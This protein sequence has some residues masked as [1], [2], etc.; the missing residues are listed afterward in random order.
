MDISCR[1]A[2]FL[3]ILLVA[4]QRSEDGSNVK[5]AIH[6]FTNHRTKTSQI[7]DWKLPSGKIYSKNTCFDY[8][9]TER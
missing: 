6:I 8:F 7:T 1:Y 4:A 9:V 5:K 2:I 3:S